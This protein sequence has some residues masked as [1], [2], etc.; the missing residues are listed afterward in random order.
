MR[1]HLTGARRLAAALTL[2]IVAVAL[3]A[4]PAGARTAGQTDD[5]PPTTSTEEPRTIT[6]SAT[7]DVRGIPDVMELTIG[8]SS[9]ES[10]AGEALLRNSER[11]AKVIDV[12][13]EAGVDEQD[14][15]TSSLYVSPA[16]DDEGENVIAYSVSNTVEARIKALDKVGKVVDAATS[17]AGNDIVVSGLSFSFDD[18]TELVTQAR[19]TAVKRARAQAEQLAAAADVQLGDLLT[20]T[21]DSTPQGPVVDAAPRAASESAA[22]AAPPVEPGSQALS[23]RVTMVYAIR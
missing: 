11:A 15:Q 5:D 8:V 19:T 21:E 12:L 4:V 3:V 22:D 2:G 1:H 18:N 6:V 9:R 10:S 23:V 17:V 20:M 16:Y 13:R 7:G 14:I